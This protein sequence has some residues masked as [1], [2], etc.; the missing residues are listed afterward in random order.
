[1]AKEKFI[2]LDT[3]GMS[4]KIPY[5]IGF[6]IADRYGKIYKSYS[7][8][9]PENIY[10]NICQCAKTQQAVE[11]TAKNVQEILQDFGN[12]RRKRKY[13][14]VSN[15]WIINF[16]LKIIQRHKI[17]K[18]Y[19]YNVAFDKTC[20]KNLFGERFEELEKVVEFIDIIPIILRTKLLTK[21]YV[22]FCI[23][24]NFL[25]ERG[26]IQTKAETVH[27]YL[28]NNLTFEEEHTG[29]SDVL[30][31]YQILLSAFS[32]HKKIDSTP[33]QAWRVLDNFCK[34]KGIV[35][36]AVA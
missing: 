6:I 5:N 16:L 19:A 14:C 26:Y 8:A 31:E 4:G 29:L 15:K 21:R 24:N 10:I 17:K 33:C 1:M 7:F 11:M 34:E 20:L 28:T 12:S 27:R 35:V 30:I 36:G 32:T 22:D 23:E 2:V 25:T 13:K 9:L 3:E 18:I